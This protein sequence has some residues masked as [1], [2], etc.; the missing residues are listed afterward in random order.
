[1]KKIILALSLLASGV[2]TSQLRNWSGFKKNQHDLYEMQFTNPRAAII[3]YNTVID[4]LGADTSG[5]TYDIMVNPIDFGFFKKPAEA[6]TM[7]I[8]ILLYED[9]VYKIMFGEFDGTRE[10]QFFNVLDENGTPIVLTY[11]PE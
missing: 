10:K 7:Y 8:S 1:M 9:E 4:K 2:V 6:R 5:F 11:R 3:K